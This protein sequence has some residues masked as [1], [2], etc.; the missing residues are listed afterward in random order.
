MKYMKRNVNIFLL[1]MIALMLM[2]FAVFTIYYKNTYR[3]LSG[4]FVDLK[5]D[6][7]VSQEEL[8]LRRA[9]LNATLEE[10]EVKKTREQS[11]SD[12]YG[13]IRDV[14]AL[15][16]LDLATTRKGLADAEIDLISTKKDLEDKTDEV[17]T[18]NTQID[19]VRDQLSDTRNQLDDVCDELSTA[20]GSHS[21]C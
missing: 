3:G 2:L 18:L 12:K 6:F 16:T 13:D 10:Y 11:L 17:K 8:A 14:N 15:L 5:D 1:F 4:T 7:E 19:G 20:G 21:Y 9:Q